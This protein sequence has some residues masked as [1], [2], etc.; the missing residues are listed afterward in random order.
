MATAIDLPKNVYVFLPIL[1]PV[2]RK[3]QPPSMLPVA[4]TSSTET[5]TCRRNLTGKRLTDEY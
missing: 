1:F 2:K 3:I 4:F 5:H